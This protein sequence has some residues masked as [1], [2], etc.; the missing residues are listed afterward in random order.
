MLNVLV[1][2][3][4]EHRAVLYTAN[5]CVS[6]TRLRVCLVLNSMAFANQQGLYACVN[7]I[8]IFHGKDPL[9]TAV[10][11][12]TVYF[13]INVMTLS[14]KQIQYD[15]KHEIHVAGSTG[16]CTWHGR[17]TSVVGV[18]RLGCLVV[19]NDIHFTRPHKNKKMFIVLFLCCG[20]GREGVFFSLF[21]SFYLLKFC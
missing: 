4:R 13:H 21:F 7:V 17:T 8:S 19:F 5:G 9:G 18:C 1:G 14:S 3:M 10:N 2:K 11:D 16:T 12:I 6:Q 15:V 20:W